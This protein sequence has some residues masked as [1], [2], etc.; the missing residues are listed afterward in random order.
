MALKQDILSILE[1]MRGIAVSGQQLADMLSVS[2]NSVWKA[3]RA[4]EQE[5]YKISASTNKGYMLD[6]AN[7]IVSAESI[8]AQLDDKYKINDIIVLKTTTS[9]NAEAMKRLQDKAIRHGTLIVSD[10]QTQG[11]GRMGKTFF[12]PKSG[13]YMSVCLCKNI[14]NMSDVMII[15]PAAA[16]AVRRGIKAFTDK[17]AKIKWV[18]DV[19]IGKKKVCGILTQADIDFESGKAGTFIVGIGINFVNQEFPDEIKDKAC[20]LFEDTPMVTRSQMIA[21]VY[22][23]LMELTDDLRDH[24][25][26]QEYKDNSLVMGKK[27]SYVISGEAKRGLVKDIDANGGLIIDEEG[28]GK[29]TLTCGEISIKSADGEWI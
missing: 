17:D 28:F 22:K 24:G 6:V 26:M 5:G 8:R 2:R 9:T 7:D 13:I 10:E 11:R 20:A 3:V 25:F 23:E 14:E 1:N 19:Y 4:L 15:T 29:R 16:V 21:K 18:N 27:I 12:S